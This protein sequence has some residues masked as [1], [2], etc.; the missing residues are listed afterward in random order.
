M[1]LFAVSLNGWTAGLKI[2]MMRR[3]K[4][5]GKARLLYK[6]ILNYCNKQ[7]PWLMLKRESGVKEKLVETDTFSKILGLKINKK[8]NPKVYV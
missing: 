2:D 5:Y 3:W 8:N 1:Q 7:I 6:M 4:A